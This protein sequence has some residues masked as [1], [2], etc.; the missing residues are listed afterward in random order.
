MPAG[1][2]ASLTA[3]LVV[4]AVC[5]PAS[6]AGAAGCAPASIP[7]AHLSTAIELNGVSALSPSNAWA[8]GVSGSGHTSRTLVEHWNG[9]HWTHVASPGVLTSPSGLIDLTAVSAH[10]ANDVWAVGERNQTGVE[11]NGAHSLIEHWNGSAWSIV[12]APD[13]P[14]GDELR[15]VVALAADDA[16]AVG[17]GTSSFDDSVVT[18]VEH[19]DGHTWSVEHGVGIGGELQGVS[20]SGPDDVWAVGWRF[21]SGANKTLAE[22]FDGHHWHQVVIPSPGSGASLDAVS[23]RSASS[24]WA[25]G[26]GVTARGHAFVFSERYDGSAWKVVKADVMSEA[27][28]VADVGP[29]LAFMVGHTSNNA[30]PAIAAWRG[31]KWSPVAN[32][33]GIHGSARGFPG[34]PFQ[35]VTPISTNAAIAVGKGWWD[36]F[37]TTHPPIAARLC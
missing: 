2:L 19:W 29:N 10:A 16:W 27:I 8:V 11:P 18:L 24:G 22:H 37:D 36:A 34:D 33:P 21:T 4:A 35:A 31:S 32:P 6:V 9:H 14:G 20:A 25:V 28:G 17:N 26:G 7:T 30:A 3:A 15:G 12:T 1:R 5:V 13:P 23:V